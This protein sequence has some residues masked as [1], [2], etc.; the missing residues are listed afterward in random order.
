MYEDTQNAWASMLLY[1]IEV[2]LMVFLC[3]CFAWGY[4]VF[5][6]TTSARPPAFPTLFAQPGFGRGAERGLVRVGGVLHLCDAPGH[7]L[8]PELLGQGQSRE[9]DAGGRAFPHHMT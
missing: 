7:D 6:H 3:W 1:G 8:L 2:D 5:D 4:H 9:E